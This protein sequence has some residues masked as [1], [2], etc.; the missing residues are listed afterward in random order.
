MTSVISSTPT[1]AAATN[2][3]NF[4]EKH[5]FAL[6]KVHS[7]AK[8]PV[9]EGWQKLS[10]R[11]LA[12]W[13]QWQAEGFNIGVHA[14]ASRIV[15]FDLDQKHGGIEAVRASFD[16]WCL[17]AGFASLP[18]HVVTPSGG[19]HIY[20]SVPDGVDAMT[21]AS[22]LKGTIGKGVD[23][24]TGDRQ[25]VAPG[26][27]FAG[28]E[29]K[30]AGLYTFRD[31]PLYGAPQAVLDFCTRA[32]VQTPHVSKAGTFDRDDVARLVTWL[33]D[34][35]EFEEYGDWLGLGMALRTEFG[36]DGKAL[37]AL[38]H[39]DTVTHDVI[40][41]K[42]RS[43]DADTKPGAVTLATFMKRAH[44]AGWTGSIRQSVGSMFAGVAQLVNS[45]S[46]APSLPLPEAVPL[47]EIEEDDDGGLCFPEEFGDDF[48]P[49]SYLV[50]GILQRRFVYSM[51]AQTGTGKTAIALLKAAHVATGRALSGRG[52]KRG[53]VLY[54]AG[55]NPDDVKAR[56]F[57]LTKE[58]GIDPKTTDVIFSYGTKSLSERLERIARTLIRR[59][60]GL[61]LVVVDT[62][63]AFFEG[64]NDND[65]VQAGNHARMLRSLV[66][67]PGEPCVLVLCHP[68]KGAKT[69]DEMVPRGGG[70]FLNEVDGN[71]ALAR[72]GSTIAMQT[73][74]K[75]RGP[76]VSP[77]HFGLHD[78]R[79]HPRLVD[80]DGRPMPTVVAHIVSE[81]GAEARAAENETAEIQMLRDIYDHPGD[82]TR[83]RA[84]RLGCHHDT[85]ASCINRLAERKM[86][87]KSG[88]KL[89]LTAKGERELN[90]LDRDKSLSEASD[91]AFPLPVPGRK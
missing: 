67:L 62:A 39:N 74:G 44:D 41:A 19:Q 17:A 43:F 38:S 25:S 4:A 69:I 90:A 12:D 26:S 86:V 2:F 56:W 82:T 6:V 47:P 50:D 31:A 35:G 40:K 48:R 45:P 81:A 16:T 30:P 72:S 91:N 9:G 3:L 22:D 63:A 71:L 15:I 59:G 58:M 49:P 65:N 33:A 79:D 66:G 87:D 64:D 11:N 18:H 13:K 23:V 60:V 42:W 53:W 37:W 20:L 57:G 5:G 55:E 75:F 7:G 83:K 32:P 36:D 34:R 14:G 29:G 78:V 51:T 70:A 24:L 27:F 1:V 52:V 89:K 76:E 77:I 61:S 68:T 28:A 54:L 46:V 88:F 21:L 80:E 8:N 10:S 85:V 73:V 84:T